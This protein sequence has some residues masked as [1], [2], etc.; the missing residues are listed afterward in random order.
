MHTQNRSLNLAFT[1]AAAVL[2]ALIAAPASSISMDWRVV[3]NPTVSNTNDDTG[4]GA[5]DHAF[6][7][8][9]YETTNAQYS[10]FLN[11]VASKEDLHGLYN[12]QMAWDWRGGIERHGSWGDFSYNV[13]PGKGNNPVNYVSFFDALRFTNWLNNGQGGADTEVGAYTLNGAN[14][15]GVLRNEGAEIF[16]SSEAEWYKAAYFDPIS[17]SFMDYAGGGGAPTCGLPGAPGAMANCDTPGHTGL[18]D[19][20]SYAN[21]TSFGTFDQ[22]GNVWELTETVYSTGK[23]VMRGGS[24][25]NS[26]S[27]ESSEIRVGWNEDSSGESYAVGFRVGGAIP[28][29]PEPGTALLMGIGHLGLGV[30]QSREK[31]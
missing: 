11:A 5:V 13:K 9:A 22:G 16:L 18:V 8:S 27:W 1:L 20:G 24:M 23:R 14:P 19:V 31:A 21:P 15:G 17:A 6:G 28:Y 25:V 26:G 4:Y 3:S 12:G 7:I 10:E 30:S 29:I 2:T